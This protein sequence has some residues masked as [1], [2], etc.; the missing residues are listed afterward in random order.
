MFGTPK[1]L[2]C[3]GLVVSLVLCAPL[4]QA[5]IQRAVISGTVS[6]S[7]ADPLPGVVLVLA[8]VVSGMNMLDQT[9]KQHIFGD[10]IRRK[11]MVGMEWRWQ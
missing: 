8:G 1:A 11:L 4:A 6:D 9:I 3:K 2:N 7:N 5:E 10:L